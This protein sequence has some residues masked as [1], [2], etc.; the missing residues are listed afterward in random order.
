MLSVHFPHP[1]GSPAWSKS[2]HADLWISQI[3]VFVNF[4]F[5]VSHLGCFVTLLTLCM[6]SESCTSAKTCPILLK[7]LLTNAEKSPCQS[8]G[9]C[10]IYFFLKSGLISPVN[11]TP[12]IALLIPSSLNSAW[13][14]LLWSSR[15]WY[16]WG[17]P[18]DTW[19]QRSFMTLILAMI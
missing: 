12:F 19:G 6:L 15:P 2:C 3:D 17:S 13:D 4:V 14:H 11:W 7:I 5:L 8:W 18:H 1:L 9:P 10:W 16:P